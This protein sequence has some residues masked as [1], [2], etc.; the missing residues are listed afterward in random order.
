MA[1]AFGLVKG[2]VS[3][4]DEL[5]GAGHTGRVGGEDTDA[6]GEDAVVGQRVW[7]SQ[8]NDEAVVAGAPW[9]VAAPRASRSGT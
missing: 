6:D 7:L 8:A 2:F 3:E 5:I 4:S 1:R 9:S